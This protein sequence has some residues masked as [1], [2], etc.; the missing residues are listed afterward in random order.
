MAF[1]Q[2]TI[3]R[4]T[5]FGRLG[6]GLINDGP[7]PTTGNTVATDPWGNV[8][9]T[10][11]FSSS[12]LTIGATTLVNT[13]GG[14]DVFV[15]KFDSTGNALWAKSG[16]GYN[17]GYDDGTALVT[18][19]NGNVYVSGTF[20]S[21]TITFSP[22]TLINSDSNFMDVFV[23][24]YDSS[25]NALLSFSIATNININ[26]VYPE[27]TITIDNLEN[28]YVAGGSLN[29]ALIFGNDTLGNLGSSNFYIVKYDSAG[30]V[31]W[32]H[33]AKGIGR[34]WGFALS[35]D[36]WNNMY[37]SGA[38]SC[39]FGDSLDF[40][41]FY[42]AMPDSAIDPMFV[43]QYDANGIPQC[44]SSLTSG[45]D[46]KNGVVADAYGNAYVVGDFM[47][48]TFKIGSN[49]LLLSGMEAAFV[50]NI[51]RSGLEA[52]INPESP[53]CSGQCIRNSNGAAFK[54]YSNIQLFM[55]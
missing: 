46:D 31:L 54:W 20:G 26:A 52:A 4:V 21:S 55:E 42:L 40:G 12:I 30:N 36:P 50:G 24:K 7:E 41:G 2:N 27:S 18:D 16:I 15:A 53:L 22:Y 14:E 34:A 9:I 23:V 3:H 45:G 5:N 10:G 37:F 51:P 39:N 38:F 43:V 28:I 1:W 17:Y 8:F 6:L 35:A 25:G 44:A 13:G 48:D 29:P 32:S 49:S 47:N 11:Q 19:N 33:G